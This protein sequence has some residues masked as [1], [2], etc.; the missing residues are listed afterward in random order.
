M[1]MQSTRAFLRNWGLLVL[2]GV[3]I[4]AT[5]AL[6]RVW[7]EHQADQPVIEPYQHYLNEVA[8][9]SKSAR[10]YLENYFAR[11]ERQSVASQH[12]EPVCAS[13]TTLAD[14]DGVDPEIVSMP[15]ARACRMLP[16]SIGAR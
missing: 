10:K 7:T 6:F 12:F 5:F 14:R 16:K 15:M 8:A 2:F 4:L 13:V 9:Q 3:S 11:Y 1:A